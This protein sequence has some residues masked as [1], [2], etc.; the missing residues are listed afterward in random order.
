[1][2]YKTLHSAHEYKSIGYNPKIHWLITIMT[3]YFTYFAKFRKSN[4]TNN[5]ILV[6]TTELIF[7]FAYCIICTLEYSFSIQQYKIIN[8][9]YYVSVLDEFV[10]IPLFF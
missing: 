4:T 2:F 3:L 10:D 5:K 1:M 9:N 6:H 7:V 8:Y